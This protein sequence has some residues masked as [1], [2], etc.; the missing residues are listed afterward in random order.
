M[1]SCSGLFSQKVCPFWILLG[2]ESR[3]Q[4]WVAWQMLVDVGCVS[5]DFKRP[6]PSQLFFS[7]RIESCHL[8]YLPRTVADDYLWLMADVRRYFLIGLSTMNDQ[9]WIHVPYDLHWTSTFDW[10]FHSVYGLRPLP[11][12]LQWS[13]A[14]WCRLVIFTNQG[15]IRSKWILSPLLLVVVVVVMV[16]VLVMGVAMLVDGWLCR[17]V[18]NLLVF[19]TSWSYVA[20]I[21]DLCSWL[22]NYTLTLQSPHGC[23]SK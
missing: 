12:L 19:G 13:Q 4:S 20:G 3:W 6:M 21:I 2:C 16:A 18:T 23:F 14:H 11:N 9:S 7:S 22:S 15:N 8:I 10:A 5:Q 1:R 17:R